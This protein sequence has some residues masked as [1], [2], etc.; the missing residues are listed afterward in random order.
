MSNYSGIKGTQIF[1]TPEMVIT[2]PLQNYSTATDVFETGY[3][4]SSW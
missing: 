3:L 1:M 4:S 2:K